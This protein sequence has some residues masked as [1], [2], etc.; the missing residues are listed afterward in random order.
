MGS[1]WDICP[2]EPD[3]CFPTV[4]ALLQLVEISS[5]AQWGLKFELKDHRSHMSQTHAQLLLVKL[6]HLAK[7]LGLE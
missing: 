5:K 4:V 2:R 6:N 1:L 3:G 7:E